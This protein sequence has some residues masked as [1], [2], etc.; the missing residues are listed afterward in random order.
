MPSIPLAGSLYNLSGTSISNYRV[1]EPIGSGGYG[2]VYRGLDVLS[3]RKLYAIK[4]M[5]KADSGSRH[6]VFQERELTLQALVCDHPNIVHLHEILSDDHHIYAVMQYCEEGDLFSAIVDRQ[7]YIH[8]DGLIKAA[9]VQL[10]DAVTYC[11][12]LAIFHR[13]IKPENVMCASKGTRV[14]LGDFGLATTTPVSSDF[15]CGSRYYM[16]PE[17]I[18]DELRLTC[19]SLPES[20]LWSLGIILYNLVSMHNPWRFATTEDSNFS[21]FLHDPLYFRRTLRLSKEA[22]QILHSIFALNPTD[23][24]CISDLRKQ[25]VALPTFY[26]RDGEELTL[27]EMGIKTPRL[28][29]QAATD[30]A[31]GSLA[32]TFVSRDWQTLTHTSG[33]STCSSERECLPKRW[34]NTSALLP[35]SHNDGISCSAA[36]LERSGTHK[37]LTGEARH[38]QAMPPFV[39]QFIVDTVGR[40]GKQA[41]RRRSSVDA[42]LFKGKVEQALAGEWE[43]TRPKPTMAKK[44]LQHLQV[45]LS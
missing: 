30:S 45:I 13:D 14:F 3:P 23:R 44:F 40:A 42:R 21:M 27:E 26:M 8:R 38:Q 41:R 36:E 6:S 20:D 33:C 25:I 12:S 31:P 18:N 35:T 32:A 11:H 9:I 22:N 16:S 17:C 34:P 2:V 19:Y 15:C 4:C 1:S 10:I 28:V 39:E 43:A 5:V 29:L 24:I 7:V 37:E